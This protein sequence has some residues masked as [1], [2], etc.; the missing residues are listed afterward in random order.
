MKHFIIRTSLKGENQKFLGT[1]IN[2]GMSN[3]SIS[4]GM[5]DCDNVVDRSTDEAF[6][7]CFLNVLAVLETRFLA[8]Q[9]PLRMRLFL[10]FACKGM[11]H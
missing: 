1:C 7:G 3:L 5:K 4:D 6:V 9:M 8:E 11:L 2:C 10:A